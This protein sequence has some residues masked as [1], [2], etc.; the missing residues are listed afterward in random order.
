LDNKFN[1]FFSNV[2]VW[3]PTAQSEIFS[4]IFKSQYQVIGIV[5][6]HNDIQK[7]IDM[8]ARA[9]SQGFNISTNHAMQYDHTL[10]NHGGEA[11][12]ASKPT[13]SLPPDADVMETARNVNDEKPRFTAMEVRIK[14]VS[15]LTI[16]AYFWCGEGLSSRNWAILQQISALIV[17]YKLRL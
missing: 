7:D 17:Q 8:N 9:N 2:S 15:M 6:T 16:V 1:F 4:D 13:F 3:G 11:I 10:G 12:L 14:N 5:E